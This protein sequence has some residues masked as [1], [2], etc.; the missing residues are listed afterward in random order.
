MRVNDTKS[1]MWIRYLNIIQLPEISMNINSISLDIA[2]YAV[3]ALQ[4]FCGNNT[5]VANSRGAT[6]P[7]HFRWLDF[8]DNICLV[9]K[10]W[11][12]WAVLLWGG[13]GNSL[14]PD[15]MGLDQSLS[16]VKAPGEGDTKIF[17]LGYG[18]SILTVGSSCGFNVTLR[19]L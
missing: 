9:K 18:K 17:R 14:H 16:A 4:G 15:F 13:E 8:T 1:K 11:I 5:L 7:L 19:L 2:G 3:I 6:N 12:L 10:G